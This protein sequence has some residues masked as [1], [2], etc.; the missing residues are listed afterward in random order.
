MKKK[1]TCPLRHTRYSGA[2]LYDLVSAVRGPD[3]GDRHGE[4]KD[5]ITARVRVILFGDRPIG[6][7][8]EDKVLN[9]HHLR[10]LCRLLADSNDRPTA[11]CLRHMHSAVIA[12]QG[13]RL[14]GGYAQRIIKA[15][16]KYIRL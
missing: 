9:K 12:S 5:I 6:G 13:H 15:L 14:W 10:V 4:L 16:E 11:H 1:V 2:N 8:T 7:V 3:Y